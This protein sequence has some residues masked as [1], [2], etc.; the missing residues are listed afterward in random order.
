[1]PFHWLKQHYKLNKPAGYAEKTLA[2]YRL[3]IR[4]GGAI[5]GV[6]I[7]AAEESCQAARNLS[8]DTVYQPD[9]AP[10]LPLP[11]CTQSEACPCVY[12]PVMSYEETDSEAKGV[13]G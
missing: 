9:D 12:R 6:R 13:S 11:D 7:Q 8:G 2:A 3:G 10:H 4:S 1:M 5:R